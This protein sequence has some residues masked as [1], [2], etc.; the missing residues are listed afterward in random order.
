MKHFLLI[1]FFLLGITNHA[2]VKDSTFLQKQKNEQVLTIAKWEEQ[3]VSAKKRGDVNTEMIILLEVL[4]HKIRDFG[5]NTGAYKDIMYLKKLIDENPNS[6]A[7]KH[8]LSDFNMNMGML[9]RDQYRYDE[10]LVYFLEAEKLAERDSIFDIYRDVS[11]HVGEILSLQGKNKEALDQFRKIELKGLP[12]EGD[13]IEYLARIYQFKAEHFFRNNQMDSTLYYAKKSLYDLAPMNMKSNRYALIADV[14]LNVYKEIDSVI[15]YANKSLDAALDIGAEREEITAHNILSRAYQKNGNY[16]EANYHFE[17]FYALQQKQR[18]F[19][20]ALLIGNLNLQNEREEANLQQ[21]LASERF[22]NQ[23]LIIWIVSIA[24]LLL[25]V[26]VFYTNNR[27]KIINKQNKI[28]EQEKL[29]AEQ[30]EK[31]KEQFLSNMSHDIRM[32][33]HAISGMLNSLR[34]QPH[35]K[36][37]NDFLDAMKISSDNLL[38]L[39]NDVLDMSKIE[40]GILD[41]EQINMN[42]IEIVQQVVSI[43]H[44]KAEENGLLLKINIVKDFPK[45]IIGDPW[46][47]NQILMNL[48]NNAIKFTKKGY[49]E[50][51]LSHS[52]DKIMFAIIDTGMGIS[53]NQKEAVFESFKQGDNIS[54]EFYGGT[55]LGLT[56]TK[57]LIEL[58]GGKIWLESEE[59]KGSI[60]YFE[61]PLVISEQTEDVQILKDESQLKAIGNELK[62]LNVLIAEDDKFNIMV[63]KDDLTWYIPEIDI[64]VVENGLLAIEYYKKKKFDVILMDV[65]MPVMNGYETAKKIREIENNINRIK[66]IPIVAMTASL[67]KNQIDKCYNAGMDSFIPKPYKPEQLIETLYNA[68]KKNL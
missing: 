15:Y 17:K 37:Q 9:L 56:I 11:N 63:V 66:P 55:G 62:G 20:N 45:T 41:I 42:V 23:R 16:K 10:S 39:L 28:I 34:R 31:H 48:V 30:S 22:S 59:N 36:S 57:K 58:Q 49:V 19:R 68:L 27:L 51:N 3:I 8:I 44:H 47:L 43:Y 2:Q 14:Y 12:F 60:F 18:S 24:L 32:P 65:Q 1:I 21:V 64:T 35:P 40:S 61:L 46:R 67:L 54:K 26:G 25:T 6:A 53:D 29:R 13:N 50:I 7:I 5:D 52:Q 33:M 4:K 38:V